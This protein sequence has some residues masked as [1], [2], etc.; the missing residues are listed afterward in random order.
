MANPYELVQGPYM[1]INEK[2]PLPSPDREVRSWW[3]DYGMLDN[4]RRHSEVVCKVA[5]VLTDWLAEAGVSLCAVRRWRWGHWRMILP[6]PPA[7]APKR[8]IS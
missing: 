4:I 8:C 7:W 1:G 3:D 2:T 5:L 6:R